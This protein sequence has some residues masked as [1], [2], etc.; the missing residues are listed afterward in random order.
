M[1][2]IEH[3]YVRGIRC[4]GDV[5]YRLAG[6]AERW[7]DLHLA[8][9]AIDA[10][11]GLLSLLMAAA[12]LKGLPR[13]SLIRITRAERGPLRALWERASEDIF[14]GTTHRDL[15]DYVGAA[16]TDLQCEVLISSSGTRIGAAAAAAI[17]AGHMPILRFDTRSWDHFSTVVGFESTDDEAGPRALLLLDPSHP[18]PWLVPFNARLD[19]SSKTNESVRAKRPYTLPYRYLGGEAWAVKLRSLVIVRAQPP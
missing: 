7:N 9:S 8:Q 14:E 19:L 2:A 16:F 11:C 4:H 13:S 6:P 15:S 10:A 18:A 1:S 17:A 5:Q 12:I 3:H